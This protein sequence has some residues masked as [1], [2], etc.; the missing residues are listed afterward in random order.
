MPSVANA[1]SCKIYNASLTHDTK[2]R[3]SKCKRCDRELSMGI[4]VLKLVGLIFL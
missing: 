1:N 4:K 3:A 2:T